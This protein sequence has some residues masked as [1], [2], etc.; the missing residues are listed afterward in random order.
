MQDGAPGA[1]FSNE[2]S[3][4]VMSSQPASRRSCAR[5]V[6]AL[7]KSGAR[8]GLASCAVATDCGTTCFSVRMT[9]AWFCST[10]GSG[11]SP[12][13]ICISRFSRRAESV[14]SAS[15]ASSENSDGSLAA[16]CAR[17]VAIPSSRFSWVS[18]CSSDIDGSAFTRARSSRASNAMTWNLVRSG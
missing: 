9:V 14:I 11:S 15:S 12:P 3:S 8:N 4:G 10:S 13:A 7:L 17:I 5:R 1:A 18:R 16:V 2:F 6:C